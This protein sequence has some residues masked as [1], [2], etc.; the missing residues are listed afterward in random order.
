LIL[1]NFQ[2]THSIWKFFHL[3]LYF[4][5]KRYSTKRKYIQIKNPSKL[6]ASIEN[7]W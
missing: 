5:A 2:I 6:S 1:D 4:R 7:L 3:R